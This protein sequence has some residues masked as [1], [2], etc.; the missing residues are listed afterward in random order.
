[1]RNLVA[2]AYPIKVWLI[3][4]LGGPSLGIFLN[5]LNDSD[6]FEASMLYAPLVIAF[7]ST[8]ISLPAFGIYYMMYMGLAKIIKSEV[9][10]KAILCSYS[11][12]AVVGTFIVGDVRTMLQ[13]TNK[14][15]F[16]FFLGYIITTLLAGILCKVFIRDSKN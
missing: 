16:L 1:M 2:R 11:C 15:G 13:P 3:T 12:I 7:V 6:S 5:I 9:I 14:D 8:F 10:L 4:L